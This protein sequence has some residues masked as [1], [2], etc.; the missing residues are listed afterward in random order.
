MVGSQPAIKSVRLL[1]GVHAVAVDGSAIDLPSASQRRLL[2][3]L[4]LHSPRR[5]RSEWLADIMGISPGALRMSVSR[6]RT[7]IGGAVLQT[8]STGYSLV[9]EVDVLQFSE[10]VAGAA[11]AGDRM[12]RLERA[13]GLWIGPALEE[14]S[15]EEWADGEIAR[16]TE[17][18]A[19]TVDDYAEEL[20]SARR[21][22]DAVAVL[23]AQVARHTYRDSS[24]GLLIRALA[25]AGRQGDALRAFQQYRSLLIEELGTE[26]SPD[27]VRIERRVATS[28]DGIDTGTDPDSDAPAR[29]AIDAVTVPL[30][31]AL[32]HEARFVGRANE[33]D[34][35]AEE[36]AL[37]RGTGLRGVVLRGEPG[38]GKTSLLA[39]FA[40]SLVSM[41]DA[42]VV[43]GRCDETGVPFQPFLSVL[44]DCVEHAPAGLLAEH[45]ARC[46]GELV[47]ICP[48]LATRVATAPDPTVSDDATERFLVF[49]AAT[50]LLRRVATPRPLVL[51]FDDLQWAEPT[52]LLMLRHITRALADAPV[53]VV[54]SS[55]ESD[56]HA[57]EQLRAALADLERGEHRGLQ[58]AG[59]DDDELA[60]LVAVAA[61]VTGD[62]E[63]RRVAAALRVETAGNP[64]YATQLIRHW[65]ESGRLDTGVTEPDLPAARAEDVPPS[66]RDVVW[67]RV[68]ALGDDASR[69]LS[70]ASVLG[71]EFSEDVLVDMVGLPESVVVETLDT[72]TRAGLLVDAGSVRRSM[73]FVHALVANALYA[74][75]GR[76]LRVRLHG[77]AARSLEQR[78]EDIGPDVVVQLARHCARAGW[79]DAAQ[80]WSTLAGDQAFEQLA[81]IEAAHHY[82]VALDIAI[83]MH[84]P[85][86]E[87]ADLLVRLG[88]AQVRAGDPQ[89]QDTLA[90]GA[91][92]ARR[93]GAHEP[94]IRAAL[95]SN[96]GFMRIDPRAPEYLA[97]VDAAV[98]VVDTTDTVTYARLL[99]L[100]AQTLVW[101]PDAERRVASA[102]K[103]LELA[104]A[105]H[106][107]TLLAR[108]APGVLWGLWEP[109]S[110][111]VRSRVAAK[112]VSV[113]EATGDPRL[114][115]GAHLSAFDIAIESADHVT[116]AR[117]LAKLRATARAIGE[118]RLRWTVGLADAF[119]ATMVGRLAEAEAAAT[120]TLELGIQIGAP[121]AFTFFAGEY[122]VI[123]TFAGRHD[124]LFPLV[125]QATK[126]DPAGLAFK[127]A[128][129]IICTAVGRGD[130]AREILDDGMASGFAELPVDNFWTTCIIGYAI[131]AIELDHADAA[132][133]LLPL[134]EPFATD[135]AFNG[136]TSQ[137]P[138]AAYVGKLESL[139]GRH[140]DAEE[141]LPR[142]ARHRRG[143]RMAVPPGDHALRARAGTASPARHA[144]RRRSGLAPRGI[145]AVPDLGIP[146]LDPPNRRAG[147][148]LRYRR[149]RDDLVEDGLIR[150]RR[151]VERRQL[152]DAAERLLDERALDH[153]AVTARDRRDV[154]V[155]HAVDGLAV[156]V[157][158]EHR[159]PRAHGT[160]RE[161][162]QAVEP[163]VL[164]EVRD[165]RARIGQ[166]RRERVDGP[167][168][169]GRRVEQTRGSSASRTRVAAARAASGR[170]R[171]T[172]RR[173]RPIGS[174]RAGSRSSSC[175]APPSPSCTPTWRWGTRSKPRRGCRCGRRRRAKG[176]SS[177]RPRAPRARRRPPTIASGSPACPCRR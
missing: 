129:G 43:Y 84:R 147:S 89:A 169:A 115:F 108:I 118:P 168:H 66:L 32:A 128:Y 114:E 77:Q 65:V 9:T 137:G 75:L 5:L 63:A 23:E 18:H 133:Q 85:D 152:A 144:R 21:S 39:A 3:I 55:R 102:H 1:G 71:I 69:I 106:D 64:L 60:A 73:R 158:V 80:R 88:N 111:A 162:P 79:P 113:A 24:R 15:G 154:E 34:A 134:L 93:S 83:A 76:S 29:A 33:L 116:A 81:P 173:A 44:A 107:P 7:A 161:H 105:H 91:D 12:Q 166:R 121:D 135:V 150:Q 155:L 126:D 27:V 103:A 82:R 101:T 97:T 16:L 20:I 57:A 48:P 145:R 37:V 120:E 124:E 45:V 6:L 172:T 47:R 87:R 90:E 98:A 141:H 149:C 170:P 138:I 35:L 143:V 70:A 175:D 14:F 95:A 38:I 40:Q 159:Q 26:P 36:L 148:G 67:S 50:D 86:A 99:A 78:T 164:V 125:E 165:R 112:A 56:G 2:A 54:A 174:A 11:D 140:D 146:D 51:M 130:T 157:G 163:E 94:L 62:V 119:T 92:L 167:V 13:L 72:A 139:V 46:G 104:E 59:F 177:E 41:A 100:L 123:G 52:A 19:G 49:E 117:S 142:R 31:S 131:L 25:S 151:R 30:P 127:L 171:R 61:P 96:I 153:G 156:L 53:L 28:W 160:E 136:V 110:A 176:R 132:V 42:T 58:L 4:A 74:D 8:A 109:G 10:A 122:F 68:N 22:A 17:L